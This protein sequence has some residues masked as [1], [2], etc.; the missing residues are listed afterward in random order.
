MSKRLK[1]MD[2]K[3]DESFKNQSLI[4]YQKPDCYVISFNHFNGFFGLIYL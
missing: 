3:W 4:K 2:K 1:Y